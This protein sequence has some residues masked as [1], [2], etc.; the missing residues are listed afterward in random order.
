VLSVGSLLGGTGTIFDAGLIT[1]AT[2]LALGSVALAGGDLAAASITTAD[3]V[4]G[5]GVI[6]TPNLT[7][8]KLIESEGGRLL[9]S[10]NVTSS[11]ALEASMNSVLEIGGT[12]NGAH[13]TF[14]GTS[15]EL[16]LDDAA[17]AQITFNASNMA[18]GDAIDLIGI[19][20]AH[21]TISSQTGWIL[22]S[23]NNTISTFGL[24]LSGGGSISI[25]ADGH[26]GSLLTVNGVLPCFARGTG[27]LCP[28]GYRKV[29]DL[30][31][32]DPV[33]TTNGQRRPVRWIGWRTL[34]LGP[35]AARTARPVL[36]SPHAFGPGRPH[37]MLR[38][39]PSHCIHI[40]GVLIPVALLVN[41][42]TIRHE[43][44]A[45]AATYFHI[46][47]DRHD[48]VLAEGLAC[49]SY[50]DD[51]NRG[52][53][54]QELG[55]R[56]PARRMYA[57][58]VAG[59]ARLAAAR[60][61]LH[62]IALGTGFATRFQPSLRALAGGQVFTPEIEQVEQ[63]AGQI[64]VAR[65]TLPQKLRELELIS[66]TACPA[67]TDPESED[68]RELGICLAT[69]RGVQLGSG[70][71][72]R[73]TGDAGTWMGARATLVLPRAAANIR[74]PLAAIAQSWGVL[75]KKAGPGQSPG[76]FP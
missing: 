46:E 48:I 1:A 63:Q 7:A 36:I 51:G 12:L 50:F 76:L 2:S 57:P 68:R 35:D 21:V 13:F 56:C 10:G 5:F 60:R 70:W 67:D 6:D 11:T 34:D 27:I 45:Q 42:A 53:M 49:E 37:K 15:A 65:F 18:A 43:T 40:N 30:R 73:A 33:I 74:L 47:L 32:N 75:R 64:R 72:A 66:T 22:D 29:E 25:A 38:L 14:A 17:G 9:L 26:G 20:P 3:N 31:P 69:M 19:A 8:A 28:D 61:Q 4:T 16:V 71:Q 41:N 55:R 24:T 23:L 54:Y 44:A 58:L 52:A 39:S 62:D 59:G